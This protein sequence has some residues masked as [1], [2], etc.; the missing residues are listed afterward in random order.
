MGDALNAASIGLVVSNLLTRG[1]LRLLEFE[2]IRQR[3]PD[4]YPLLFCRKIKMVSDG[5]VAEL[6]VS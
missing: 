6:R 1:S 3:V 2:T 4:A 5:P